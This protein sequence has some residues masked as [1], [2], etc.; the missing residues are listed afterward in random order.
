MALLSS[1][2]SSLINGVSQQPA[3]LRFP[4]QVEAQDNAY[5]SIASGLTKRHP[6]QYVAGPLVGVD[7][8]SGAFSHL[9]NRD[10]SER[11]AVVAYPSGGEANLKVFDLLTG[12]SKTIRDPNGHRVTSNT[13][14]NFPNPNTANC[15]SID[16][17]TELETGGPFAF[18]FWVY[19]PPMSEGGTGRHGIISKMEAGAGEYSIERTGKNLTVVMDAAATTTTTYTDAFSAYEDWYQV[20]VSHNGEAIKVYVDGTKIGDAD[21]TTNTAAGSVKFRLGLVSDSSDHYEE[22]RLQY[23]GFWKSAA[24]YPLSDDDVTTLYNGGYGLAYDGL[25]TDLKTDLVSFWNLEE[26][27]GN[28]IDKAGSHTLTEEGTVSTGDAAPSIP[29]PFNYID[30]ADMASNLRAVTVVDHTWLVDSTVTAAMDATSL[31]PTRKNE[32]LVVIW[33]Y[34]HA[35]TYKITV[36]DKT[37]QFR[38]R[39][40]SVGTETSDAELA[41]Q[42]N[43]SAAQN[44]GWLA[45]QLFVELAGISDVTTVDLS[46]T[47]HPAAN[48]AG[49]SASDV[50]GTGGLVGGV[51]INNDGKGLDGDGST[52]GAGGYDGWVVKQ[53]GPVIHIYRND[54]ADF[55]ISVVDDAGDDALTVIKDEVQIL[56]DLPTKAPHGMSV[57]IVG[58]EESGVADEYYVQFSVGQANSADDAYRAERQAGATATDTEAMADGVWEEST[59]SGIP[60]KIDGDTMPHKLVRLS[61]GSFIFRKAE[62]TKMPVGDATTNPQASFI[63]EK[64]RDIFFFKNRLGLLADDNV[65]MS[66]TGGYN[67][68]WRTKIVQLLD[69]DPID[70]GIAHTS[71]AKVN[72]AIPFQ[73]SLIL[74]TDT[75]Q[76]ILK[77]D[78]ILSPKTT[79]IEYSTEFENSS[80]VRPIT[81]GRSIFFADK[82]FAFSGVREWYQVV[83]DEMYDALDITAHVPTYIPGQIVTLAGST[84]DNILAVRADGDPDAIYIYKYL[85]GKDEKVQSAWSRYTL[86]GATILD[87][88]WIDTSLYLLLQ[89]NNGSINQMWIERMTIEPGITD[90]DSTGTS[91]GFVCNLDRR[92]DETQLASNTYVA[93]DDETTFGLPYQRRSV[94]DYQVVIRK[95]GEF[96]GREYPVGSQLTVLNNLEADDEIRVAGDF[97]GAE[98]Y[99]GVKYSMEIELS[100]AYLKPQ[101]NAPNYAT[102]RY[103]LMYGHLIYHDSDY[104]RVEVQP[105]QGRTKRTT[106]FSGG[107][108]GGTAKIGERTNASGQLKFAIYGRSDQ[109]T[110]RIINDTPLSSSIMGL[111]YEAQFNPRATRIG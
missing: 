60:D 38:T 86:G 19:L 20:V 88:H 92:L 94:D 41:K 29:E 1:P 62:W 63:G 47:M 72:H 56:A 78:D 51:G 68:F 7:D 48:D 16:S 2:V 75:S 98:V 12:S 8:I 109:T 103:Q 58:D 74:F 90:T 30:I 71:V 42:E 101:P 99:L 66:E 76:F 25:V 55:D 97:S 82:K 108:L 36:E 4:S 17:T 107:L 91:L 39:K 77:S 83:R 15:F 49:T 10:S 80:S 40:S 111:E 27:S 96:E 21:V 106:V 31:T 85:V 87:M 37:F 59:A 18:S 81:T 104:I 84:H 22:G 33:K 44:Q 53:T 13:A 79:T 35:H 64:I 3:S 69:S 57:K 67:T 93:G 32:A 26:A 23:V 9:I 45:E 24:G 43:R 61:D 28:A 73:N 5:S 95:A 70:V 110:I 89:I 14:R 54:E 52:P 6:S 11:Y 50:W 65:I 102:G 46:A 34:K 105:S 100:Q